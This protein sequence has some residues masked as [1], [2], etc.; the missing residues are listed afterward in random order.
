MAFALQ[1]YVLQKVNKSKTT[2][3]E[4][5]LRKTLDKMQLNLL[6]HNT[7]EVYIPSTPS[8]NEVYL[9]QKIGLKPLMPL[10]QANKINI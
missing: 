3:T 7:Q 6:K 2:F 8:E 1:N 9:Q 4:N 5:S 10:T